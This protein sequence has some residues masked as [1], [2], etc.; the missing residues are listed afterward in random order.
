MKQVIIVF[1]RH[2]IDAFQLDQ[3]IIKGAADKGL[4]PAEME[5]VTIEN[6]LGLGSYNIQ[7]ESELRNVG[8]RLSEYI[9]KHSVPN[10]STVVGV[11]GVFPSM[12]LEYLG[13][14]TSAFD[15]ANFYSA[16]N[17]SRTPEGGKP[18][19]EFKRW[20]KLPLR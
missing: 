9:L 2:E 12:L 5:H 4:E 3:A 20:C 16:W 17:T 18:T 19:F 10:E 11:F 1:T 7:S 14:Y 8:N 15:Y 6:L 13:D